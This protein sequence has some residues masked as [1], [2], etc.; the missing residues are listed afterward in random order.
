MGPKHFTASMSKTLNLSLSYH[1]S[2]IAPSNQ[3][4]KY[5]FS[6]VKC[7]DYLQHFCPFH[8]FTAAPIKRITIETCL[9]L[10]TSSIKEHL[11]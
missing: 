11:R 3:S 5:S 6:T 7:I 9:I 2:Q 1:H 10:D 8:M 4:I